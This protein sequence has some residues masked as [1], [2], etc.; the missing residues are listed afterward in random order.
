MSVPD[1]T[2]EIMAVPGITQEIR[3]VSTGNGIGHSTGQGLG[4][5]TPKSNT[6]NRIFR[7]G[8]GP[9]LGT[10]VLGEL[11]VHAVHSAG[12]DAPAQYRTPRSLLVPQRSTTGPHNA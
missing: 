4:F 7:V 6:R 2:Q 10:S 11:T 3:S 12:S 9:C 1:I 8:Y 5:Y